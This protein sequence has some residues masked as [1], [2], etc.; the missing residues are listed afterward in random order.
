MCEDEQSPSKVPGSVLTKYEGRRRMYADVAAS[1]W[2]L[3]VSIKEWRIME[4]SPH[5][6]SSI[7][8]VAETVQVNM[9]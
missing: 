5:F 1:N 6:A 2:V 3:K 4:S 9:T 8:K 7:S